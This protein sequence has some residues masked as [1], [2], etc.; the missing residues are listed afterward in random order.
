MVY[1]EKT[2]D[3]PGV[4]SAPLGNTDWGRPYK[5]RR[6]VKKKWGHPTTVPAIPGTVPHFEGIMS[7]RVRPPQNAMRPPRRS[8][9][10]YRGGRP[11]K[12]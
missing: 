3:T 8:I 7:Y 4:L 1:Q 6:K 12:R 5:K 9:Q 11:Q 2:L 10:P